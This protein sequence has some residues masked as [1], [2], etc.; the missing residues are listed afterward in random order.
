M[1]RVGFVCALGLVAAAA[2]ATAAPLV[3]RAEARVE[4]A[5][6]TSCTVDLTI[7]VDAGEVEHRLDAARGSRI[8]LIE[9]RGADTVRGP[10]DIGQTKALVLRPV[11]QDYTLRY[12]VEQPPE[13]AGRCPLWIP[14]VPTEG[15]GQ[16]VRIVARIPPGATAVGTMPAF[17]WSGGE[18]TATI[19]HLPAFV[20][21]PY[22]TAGAPAPWNIA[23]IMDAASLATLAGATLAWV[24]YR[25][26]RAALTAA[27][28]GSEA[29]G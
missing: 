10:A 25:R 23:A 29:T 17:T 8:E 15:R 4:F 24:R 9:V 1:N 16:A 19:G 3:R 26:R 20:R 28:P 21:V 5:S 2:A 13:R 6:P 18:G 7:A 27:R 14:T 22:A 12:T 11:S